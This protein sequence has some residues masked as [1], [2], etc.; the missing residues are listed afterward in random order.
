M[1]RLARQPALG[2]AVCALAF[3]LPFA[4][5]ALEA[6]CF[7][8]PSETVR[9]GAPVNGI[10]AEVLP[11]RGDWVDAGSVLARLDTTLQ[12][13]GIR[14]ARA[15]ADDRAE[16]SASE[17]RV[18]FLTARLDRFRT[19]AARNV[20][21]SAQVEETE[22]ELL[23]AQTDLLAAERNIALA[24]ADL[25]IAEAERDRRTIRAPI[26]GYVLHRAL[27]SG[28]FWSESETLLTLA[29]IDAL[30]VEA[31]VDIT[32]FPHITPG[33]FAQVTPEEPFNSPL[34]AQV[35]VIDRVFDAASGTFGVRLVLENPDRTLP[36]GLRC[37]VR[38]DP[39][40]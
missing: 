18:A 10:I 32:A 5:S 12:D 38:F 3:A 35:D 33:Q 19:L 23:V 20:V 14:A 26:S 24:L 27:S 31:A 1:T 28:E 40:E 7:I 22:T 17:A 25:E 8:R 9:V 29:A 15:R 2:A 21:S 11:E 34:S 37:V 16:I 4:A 6:D 36:A 39:G 30:H 13:M